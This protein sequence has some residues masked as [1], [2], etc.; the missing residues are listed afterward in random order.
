MEARRKTTIYDVATTSGVSASTVG[1]VLNGSWA[2]RRISKELADRVLG[3]AAD[4]GYRQNRQA[5]A[6]RT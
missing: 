2:K 6:L 5:S 3:V 4:L 1:S